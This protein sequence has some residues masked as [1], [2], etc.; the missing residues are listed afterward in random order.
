MTANALVSDSMTADSSPREMLMLSSPATGVELDGVNVVLD[1][2]TWNGMMCIIGAHMYALLFW[3]QRGFVSRRMHAPL[4][5]LPRNAV[6]VS[7]TAACL[8]M[9]HVL[10]VTRAR[11][12]CTRNSCNARCMYC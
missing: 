5:M 7:C 1:L 9:L 11:V 8:Y 12:L 10:Q 4:P 3:L 2:T 6:P